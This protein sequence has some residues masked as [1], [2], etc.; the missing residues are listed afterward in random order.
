MVRPVRGLI[1]GCAR[2]LGVLTRAVG[3]TVVILVLTEIL[4][5]GRRLVT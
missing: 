2:A 3:G 4:Q 5:S 1:E